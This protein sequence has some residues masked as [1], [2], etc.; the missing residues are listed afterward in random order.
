MWCYSVLSAQCLFCSVES[1]LEV[2]AETCLNHQTV[3]VSSTFE[4]PIH[5]HITT[6]IVL[7]SFGFTCQPL[8]TRARRICSNGQPYLPAFRPPFVWLHA[9][10]A[11][12]PL[13]QS[14]NLSIFDHWAEGP[15][16]CRRAFGS[17]PAHPHPPLQ[18]V[19]FRGVERRSFC[20]ISP[21]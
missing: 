16:R 9:V 13:P 6:L 1:M 8:S 17:I 15:R 12:R 2:L 21:A 19:I 11:A 14:L 7:G 20:H 4:K 3:L 10:L 5:T 18:S